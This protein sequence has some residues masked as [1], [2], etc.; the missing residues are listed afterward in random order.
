MTQGAGRAR[1][2]ALL[3]RRLMARRGT[4]ILV[5]GMVKV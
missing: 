2:R 1:V 4:R 3:R 5:I